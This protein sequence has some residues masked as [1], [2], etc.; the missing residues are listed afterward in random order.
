MMSDT[1]IDLPNDDGMT[2]YLTGKV[3]IHSHNYYNKQA[4]ECFSSTGGV[5]NISITWS[6]LKA[7]LFIFS[8]LCN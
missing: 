5:N 6:A 2:S 3:W 8:N 1:T 7:S 4:K